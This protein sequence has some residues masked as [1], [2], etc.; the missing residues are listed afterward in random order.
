MA[1]MSKTTTDP[2]NAPPSTTPNLKAL[3]SAVLAA[4]I[5]PTMVIGEDGIIVYFN[6]AACEAF[7]VDAETA[8]GANVSMRM[9]DGQH[10]SQ[11]DQYL[12][13]YKKTGQKKMIGR[14]RIV[15]CKRCDDG[16]RWNASLSISEV[17]LENKNFFVGTLRDVT[18]SMEREKLFSSVIDEAID[19]IFTINEKGIITLVNRSACEMFGYQESELIDHNISILMPE[20]HRSAHDHYI[21]AHMKTGV[22]K[23]IGTDR[24]V[25]AKRKDNSE[26][27]CRLGLSKINLSEDG[28]KATFVGLLHDLT[29]ELA[30][31]EADARAELANKMRQQKSLVSPVLLTYY[32][33]I[34]SIEI[35]GPP[36]QDCSLA[37]H[38]LFFNSIFSVFGIHVARNSHPAQWYF[39]YARTLAVYRT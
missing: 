16:S 29:H 8:T 24:T 26:F 36:F 19:A 38:I 31:R 20:P 12:K 30:A 25:T 7:G 34:P 1:P 9:G 21:Q 3:S 22:Q 14:N 18:Q 6:Q 5:D 33:R 15:T 2:E 35:G 28:S 39:W 27:K 32:M 23:M 13:A 37:S 17:T 11:H 10:S 4:V